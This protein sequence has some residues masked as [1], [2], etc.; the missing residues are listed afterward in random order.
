MNEKDEEDIKTSVGKKYN[1][2]TKELIDDAGIDIQEWVSERKS[3][4]PREPK[5][6]VFELNPL[7]TPPIIYEAA[8]KDYKNKLK[9]TGK[10]KNFIDYALE[11]ADKDGN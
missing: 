3:R 10:D 5:H 1:G 8:V 6:L 2:P 7:I 11:G 9:N 4:V